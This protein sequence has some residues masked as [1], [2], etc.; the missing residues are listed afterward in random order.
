MIEKYTYL[1]TLRRRV[2]D[3]Y[4]FY[5]NHPDSS[6]LA[7]NREL[8]YWKGLFTQAGLYA[9]PC[10]IC[11]HF[12]KGKTLYGNLPPKN[13]SKLK[14]WNLVH[15]YLIGTYNRSQAALSLKIMLVSPEWRWQTPSQAGSE[16]LRYQRT[17]SM[18][19]RLVIRSTQIN[20]LLR[21]DSCLTAHG[22]ADTRVHPKV[23]FTTYLS[24]N[25]S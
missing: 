14:P 25:K 21:L 5:F 13:I 1:Q 22:L 15:L 19:L 7:K 4:H 8:C 20:Q 11:Q 17:T 3:W 18:R 2:L 16:F 10:K 23:C 9:K 12:K 6:R 24:L